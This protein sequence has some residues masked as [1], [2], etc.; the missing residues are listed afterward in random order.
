MP[1][2]IRSCRSASCCPK[3]NRTHRTLAVCT[4]FGVP[5][6]AR[7]GGTSQAGQCIGPGV[8][9]DFSKYF[10]QVLEINAEEKWAR[11]EPGVVLDDLNRQV[12]PLGL[13]F[14]PDISTS[15]RAT[16]G[17]MVANNSSGTHSVIHGKTI[18]HVLGLK[19]A[20]ADGSIITTG[21]LSEA[22][23]DERCRQADLEGACYRT[24]RRLAQE[25]ADEIQRRFPKIL[26]RVGGYNLDRFVPAASPESCAR[27]SGQAPRPF[28]L[29][30]IF[31]GSEGTLG[32]T[33][34][35]KVKLIDLPKARASDGRA[36]CRSARRSRSHAPNSATSARRRSKS[37][38]ASFSTAPSSTPKRADCAI[39]WS[40]IRGPFCWSNSTPI[41]PSNC[42]SSST[43]WKPTCVNTAAAALWFAPWTLPSR[44]ASGSCASSPSVCRWRR[45]ATPRRSPSSKTPPWPRNICAITLPSFCKRFAPMGTTAGVYAHASV[46]CL[47]VRPVINLKTMEGIHQF[48]NPGRTRWPTWCSSTAGPCPANMATAWCAVRSWRRCSARCSTRPFVN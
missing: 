22:E 4:R 30:D 44:I 6:T 25:H 41:S 48:R 40:A 33:L 28:N 13:Q 20:L 1:A 36:F 12:K 35:A 9:L 37:S 43:R 34:Q 46:G 2:F 45:R 27:S 47:H 5:I 3:R 8:V 17:G 11:V 15:N 32:I 29:S 38:T 23:L 19:V 21:P 18:D 24:V 42:Q 31:V 16:I 14:A 39:S 7:G 10:D 26:R